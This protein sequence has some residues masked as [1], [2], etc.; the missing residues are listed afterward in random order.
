[1]K[2]VRAVILTAGAAAILPFLLLCYYTVPAYIDDYGI[3]IHIQTYGTGFITHY[4]NTW[5]GRFIAA[6]FHWFNPLGYRLPEWY[7]LTALLL[8]LFFGFSL[9]VFISSITRNYLTKRERL[10]AWVIF[11][12]FF[13]AYIRSTVDL[14]YWYSSGATYCIA[15]CWQLL[16][17]ALLPQLFRHNM[18]RYAMLGMVVL[19]FLQAGT[20]EV[21]AVPAFIV[22][23]VV[24]I[25]LRADP[26][27]Q[28]SLGIVVL[29][30]SGIILGIFLQIAL[31]NSPRSQSI[32]NFSPVWPIIIKG[33]RTHLV[34][35]LGWFRNLPLFAAFLLLL[36][37]MSRLA[38]KNTV[39]RFNKISH[40]I[41]LVLIG[42]LVIVAILVAY[43]LFNKDQYIPKRIENIAYMW[44]LLTLIAG[45]FAFV[46][47]LWLRHGFVCNR[48]PRLLLLAVIIFICTKIFS[49]NTKVGLAWKVLLQGDA[50]AYK[51]QYYSRHRSMMKQQQLDFKSVVY[52]KPIRNRLD[53]LLLIDD[54]HHQYIPRDF[55]NRAY[56]QYFGMDSVLVWKNILRKLLDD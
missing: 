42:G 1:M 48:M 8:L 5:N 39:F 22:T 20:N 10:V 38:K 15:I 46:Q 50:R 28:K 14:F 36:P 21:V 11:A 6:F 41:G 19:A 52:L 25:L 44:W 54:L 43:S 51:E 13:L 49:V 3:A 9:W 53:E 29:S 24:L 34:Y 17:L 45:C 55:N 12:T 18:S 47:Y 30:L 33:L 7:G 32:A 40:V 4:L 56:A 35:V 37:E 26:K 31:S 23:T 27:H 16:Y 2:I